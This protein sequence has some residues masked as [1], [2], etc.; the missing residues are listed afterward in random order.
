MIIKSGHRCRLCLCKP[1]LLLV[2]ILILTVICVSSIPTT[3]LGAPQCFHR[4]SKRLQPWNPRRCRASADISSDTAA[5]LR[6]QRTPAAASYLSVRGGSFDLPTTQVTVFGPQTSVEY[7]GRDHIVSMYTSEELTRGESTDPAGSCQIPPFTPSDSLKA[8][9]L[10]PPEPAS[11][12][13][14]AELPSIL[15]R[16]MGEYSFVLLLM[17]ITILKLLILI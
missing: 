7:C 11:A 5:S 1:A 14:D 12:T 3:K 13:D 4:Y 6:S 17:P 16:L 10:V 8:T 9:S 15:Y 2:V